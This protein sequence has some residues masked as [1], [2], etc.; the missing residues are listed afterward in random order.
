MSKKALRPSHVKLSGGLSSLCSWMEALP[1]GSSALSCPT[2]SFMNQ[3]PGPD[4]VVTP[5]KPTLLPPLDL[6]LLGR[7]FSRTC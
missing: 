1:A 2:P 6:W 3:P 4:P 7:P 5:F